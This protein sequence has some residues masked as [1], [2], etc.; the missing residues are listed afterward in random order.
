MTIVCVVVVLEE[1]TLI[2]GL[3]LITTVVDWF[4]KVMLGAL[5]SLVVTS[6]VVVLN[7]VIFYIITGVLISSTVVLVVIDDIIV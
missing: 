2:Y 1:V 6:M 5:I 4:E 3:S 7:D